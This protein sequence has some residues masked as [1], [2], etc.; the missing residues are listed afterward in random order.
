MEI[1]PWL[2]AFGVLVVAVGIGA[3]ITKSFRGFPEGF[4]EEPN[5]REGFDAASKAAL[6][7][8]EIKFVTCKNPVSRGG[9]GKTIEACTTEY[10]ACVKKV[11]NPSVSL[12]TPAASVGAAS[13]GSSAPGAQAASDVSGFGYTTTIPSA[14]YDALRKMALTGQNATLTPE[15]ETFL[16]QVQ[17][18]IPTETSD[19]T[20]SELDAAQG[21]GV[22]PS[23]TGTLRGSSLYKPHTQ[24]IYPHQT[25]T[26]TSSG[27]TATVPTDAGTGVE[28]ILA[29]APALASIRSMVRDDIKKGVKDEMTNIRNNYELV[30]VP[31]E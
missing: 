31:Q 11:T 3:Y 27:S 5:I 21:A 17:S 6:K 25:P 7:L 26:Q 13:S 24:V 1:P 29:N 28:A 8:C 4:R 23:G 15:L 22:V 16:K 18:A 19:P 10:D 20:Q 14:D 9:E 30:L 12:T 2:L